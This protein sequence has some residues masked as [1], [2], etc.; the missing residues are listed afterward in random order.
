MRP[1]GTACV[2]AALLASTQAHAGLTGYSA[3]ASRVELPSGAYRVL[4]VYANF[5]DPNDRL[6]SVYGA[7]I[8]LSGELDPRFVHASDPDSELPPSFLPV[9]Y[10]APGELWAVDSFVTIGADQGNPINGTIADPDF[11]D[12]GAS[13]GRGISSGGWYNLPPT[14]GFGNA[15]PTRRVLIGQF[16]IPETEYSADATLHVSLTAAVATQ[17]ILVHSPVSTQFSFNRPTVYSMDDLDGD[18]KS[19]VLFIQPANNSLFG[20]L[21]DGT[22]L[23]QL[24]FLTSSG[25]ANGDLQG[26]GDID[27]DGRADI[28][29]RNRTSGRFAV[30]LCSGLSCL[31]T[32]EFAYNPGSSW[33]CAAFNDFDG[34]R[35]AD[36]LFFNPSTSQVAIWLLDGPSLRAGGLLGSMPGGKILGVGDLN[37]DARRDVL[38]RTA[39]GQ[40]WGWLLDGTAAPISQRIGSTTISTDWVVPVIADFDGDRKD[41]VLWRSRSSGMVVSWKMNG[42]AF[43]DFAVLSA[44]VPTSWSIESAPDID[45]D[46]RREVF[47]RN[48]S[49]GQAAMWLMNSHS[50]YGGGYIS[51]ASAAWK[52]ANSVDSLQP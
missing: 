17:Q 8:T 42:L 23:K 24:G 15:G 46:G 41:D 12:A 39:N 51:N 20:W 43:T 22:A 34:D 7:H 47:W 27:G 26:I 21:L 29:W 38:W 5:S 16:A 37:G 35:R 19:D 1:A 50:S 36:I 2:L 28:L 25:P 40:I 6:L 49:T 45:G 11:D 10:N 9:G 33:R 52:I 3:V 4:L 31:A 18:S 30:T 14:N 32:T 48:R 13:S 44:G